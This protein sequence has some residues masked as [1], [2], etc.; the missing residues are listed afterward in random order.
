MTS[1]GIDRYLLELTETE[2]AVIH[3]IVIA[4]LEKLKARS[5]SV[6]EELMAKMRIA[7]DEG[8]REVCTGT[9]RVSFRKPIKIGFVMC[10]RL[11]TSVTKEAFSGLSHGNQESFPSH[12]ESVLS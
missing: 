3:H 10:I 2:L 8:I 12:T 6:R 11:T 4:D 5:R 7:M 1:F 9:D